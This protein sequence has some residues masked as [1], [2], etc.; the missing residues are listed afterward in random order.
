LLSFTVTHTDDF[1]EAHHERIQQISTLNAVLIT[2]SMVLLMVL[3]VPLTRRR[4]SDACTRGSTTGVILLMSLLGGL[5]IAVVVM[6][7]S[8]I[9]GLTHALHPRY[10]S[11]LIHSRERGAVDSETTG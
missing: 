6:L 3:S 2:L 5:L 8:T 4:P 9:R 7:H 10:E 11:R 1:T